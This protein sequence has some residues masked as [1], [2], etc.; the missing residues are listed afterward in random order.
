MLCFAAFSGY[1]RGRGG[2]MFPRGMFRGGRPPMP[3]PPPGIRGNRPPPPPHFF[4]A[5]GLRPPMRPPFIGGPRPPGPPFGPRPPPFNMRGPPGV[6][7]PPPG[8]PPPHVLRGHPRGFHHRP[9][10]PRMF[11]P[12]PPDAYGEYCEE[13]YE[14]EEFPEQ[15]QD[16]NENEA[17]GMQAEDSSNPK[18]LMA[19]RTPTEIKKEVA[20]KAAAEQPKTANPMGMG[21]G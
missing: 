5:R 18:P 6:R 12:P 20:A 21:L 10:L 2:P 13:G 4:A 3:G 16:T 19:I 15:M 9:G 8:L 11:R 7:R 1:I 17:D 14:G